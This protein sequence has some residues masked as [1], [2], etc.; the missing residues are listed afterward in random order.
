MDIFDEQIA[1]RALERAAND[2]QETPAPHI[3]AAS[4]ELRAEL[5]QRLPA[6]LM[7]EAVMCDE[8]DLA[9]VVISKPGALLHDV[10]V[11]REVD[12]PDT[13]L[14]STCEV[15]ADVEAAAH[16]VSRQLTGQAPATPRKRGTGKGGINWRISAGQ[17]LRGTL[18]LPGG[19]VVDVWVKMRA[20]GG[21]HVQVVTIDTPCVK[22]FDVTDVPQYGGADHDAD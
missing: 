14:V 10:E 4:F 5:R 19:E 9:R 16:L 18:T 13:L 12:D 22:A 15:C 2:D 17:Q 7:V 8:G 11:V 3:S 21:A 1:Q 6:H 20:C